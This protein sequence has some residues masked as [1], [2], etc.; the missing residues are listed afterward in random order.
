MYNERTYYPIAVSVTQTAAE[1]S[2]GRTK[3]YELISDGTLKTLK[4]GRRTLVTMASI[5]ALVSQAA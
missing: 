1:L 2:L 4:V 3:V 5:L